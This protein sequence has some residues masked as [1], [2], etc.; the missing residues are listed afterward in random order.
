MSLPLAGRRIVVTRPAGQAAGLARLIREA[1]GEPVV[2]P[3]LEIL[4]P[5]DPAALA[6]VLARLEQFD[7]AIFISRNAVDWGLAALGRAW[8]ARVRVAAV[9]AGTARALAERG[10]GGV[11]AP[12]GPQPD[13]EALLA[14]PELADVRTARVLIFRGEGGREVLRESL[15]ARGAEVEYAECYRRARPR[16]E[17]TALAAAWARGELDAAT[18]NSAAALE[19]LCALIG[20]AAVRA[21]RATPL[22]VP[23]PRVAQAAADLG[24]ARIVVAG[25]SDDEMRDRLVAYFAAQSFAP[26]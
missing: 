10:I 16:T 21:A 6:A 26:R 8:P 24:F 20:E 3:A 14:R 23:H 17:A 11:I 19:N 18:V 5:A 12:Q 7:L 22:F 15:V 1:G 2:F 13:S 4:P 9:G 25:P